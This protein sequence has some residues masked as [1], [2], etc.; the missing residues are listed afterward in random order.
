[1]LNKIRPNVLIMALMLCAIAILMV[2]QVFSLL[3]GIAPETEF[4]KGFE[5]GAM[6]ASVLMI[7]A[8]AVSMLGT[9][10]S[11]VATDPPPPTVPAKMHEEMM[12]KA[13]D[14]S[15]NVFTLRRKQDKRDTDKDK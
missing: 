6:L 12:A 13:M 1:M 8:G 7:L 5:L 11:Q 14:R 3:R 15:E 9:V 10:M 2:F 4:W